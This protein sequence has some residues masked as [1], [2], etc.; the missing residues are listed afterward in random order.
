MSTFPFLVSV[1]RLCLPACL[2]LLVLSVAS[3]EVRTKGAISKP[4]FDPSAERVE[5]FKGVDE[6]LL[7]VKVVAKD[8]MAGTVFVQNNGDQ[9]VTV[10]VPKAIV[11]VHVLKQFGD[12]G[13][14]FGGDF[15]GGDMGGGGGGGQAFGGGMGGGGMMGGMGGYGGGMGGMGGGGG[16][17]SIPPES[18]V[19]V[20]YRSVCLDHGKPEPRPAMTYELVPVEKY[21]DNVA[22]Q[23]LLARVGTGRIDPQAAQA[24]AWVLDDGMSWQ[25]LAAK[26]INRAGG[27]PDAPYFSPVQLQRAQQAVAYFVARS[28]EREKDQSEEPADETTPAR[29]RGIRAALRGLR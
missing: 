24:A 8:A 22:L 21:T 23:E 10:E 7:E 16:F 28:R 26:K 14:D 27:V 25:E 29:A 13:G 20:P 5:L 6:G 18:V 17:F 19:K 12:M 15:G 2:S 3:A 11:G 1:R 4:K 9:P